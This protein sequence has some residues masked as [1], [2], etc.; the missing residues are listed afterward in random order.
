MLDSEIKIRFSIANALIMIKFIGQFLPA[1]MSS[2]SLVI[3]ISQGFKLN[4]A[5][6]IEILMLFKQ[7]QEPL[8][9]CIFSLRGIYKQR[10]ICTRI[11]KLFLEIKEIKAD[12]L[13]SRLSVDQ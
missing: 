1:L 8:T 3:F 5:Q 10:Q 12:K 4:L 2:L 9:T 13:V 6:T 11:L 7:A